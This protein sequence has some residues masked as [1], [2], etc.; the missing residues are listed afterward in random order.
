M[1]FSW[2][3]KGQQ[4]VWHAGTPNQEDGE[5][6]L[7]VYD[8]D[9]ER[10]QPLALLPGSFAA[11]A[12]SPEGD[13]WLG[14][15]S[16]GTGDE[17]RSVGSTETSVQVTVS[18][19]ETAFSWSPNGRQVAYATRARSG[20]P[21]YGPVQ[22][23]DADTGSTSQVT[24]DP[25]RIRA[26]FWSPDG[27]RLAYL[28]WLDLP[29]ETWAQWRVFDLTTGRDRGFAAFNPTPLMRFALYSF[30]QYA[31]SHRLWSPDGRYLVYADRD[32]AAVDRIWLVDTWAERG[33]DPILIGEGTLAYWSWKS[34]TVF[35]P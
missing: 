5:A 14:V 7:A 28:T 10:A 26:F 30:G 31:Q 33:A 25:F 18:A 29:N 6:A 24:D 34:T 19:T 27:E 35:S 32:I 1:Y 11:P 20:D 4:L 3:P 22:V 21:F 17:L 13:A 15:L 9:S 23:L 8:L 16:T 2:S 12:W